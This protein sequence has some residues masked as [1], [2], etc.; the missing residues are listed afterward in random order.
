[1]GDSDAPLH[2]VVMLGDSAVGKTSTV[3]LLSE[4]VFRRTTPTVGSFAFSRESQ[5][6]KVEF[7][8]TFGTQ[9]ARGDTHHSLDYI[10]K[11]YDSD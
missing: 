8:S 9:R 7:A 1:M 5:Q 6:R 4:H 3:L 2:K 11:A 10:R